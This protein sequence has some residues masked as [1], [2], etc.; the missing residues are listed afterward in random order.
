MTPVMFKMWTVGNADCGIFLERTGNREHIVIN[1]IET[2]RE[3]VTK[4]NSTT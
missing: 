4:D 1:C 2:A 3:H